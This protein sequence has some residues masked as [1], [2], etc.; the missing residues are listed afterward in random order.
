MKK[1]FQLL[2]FLL[3]TNTGITQKVT[4]VY[5]G[6]MEIDSPKNT[7]NFEL[8]LKEKKGKLYG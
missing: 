3:L 4:G 1:I 2:I 7:I 6:Y 8:T 5:K